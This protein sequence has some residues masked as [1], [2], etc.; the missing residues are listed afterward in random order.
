M[1][2]ITV[3]QYEYRHTFATPWTVTMAEDAL[4]SASEL[5]SARYRVGNSVIRE[6]SAKHCNFA[7]DDCWYV[8]ILPRIDNI[9]KKYGSLAGNQELVITG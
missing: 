8:R 9:D 2:L 1:D 7:N 5:P 4:P 6:G 3:E